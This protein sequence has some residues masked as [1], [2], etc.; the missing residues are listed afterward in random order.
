MARLV[1]VAAI[2]ILWLGAFAQKPKASGSAKQA[3]EKFMAGNYEGALEE[4]RVLYSS[5]QKN[6]KYNY[7]I[8]ICYLNTNIDKK[9]AIPYLEYVTS[10]D[11]Y[12][13]NALYLLGRAYHFANRFD[14][15]IKAYS[16]FKQKGEGTP[17]NLQ[18]ADK[19]IEFCYNA[20][21][22]IKFPLNVSFENLGKNVNSPYID[23][24]PFVPNDE[25]FLVYNSRRDEGAIIGVD[26]RF[27]ADVFMSVEKGGKWQKSKP[28]G[29]E[30]N[31]IEGDEE[32]AGLSADGNNAIFHFDNNIGFGDLLLSLKTGTTFSKPLHLGPNINSKGIEIAAAIAPGG[33]TV[34]FASNRPGGYGGMDLYK[35]THLPNGEWSEAF[36]LG[37]IINTSSDEDFPTISHDGKTLYFSSKGHTTMGGYDIFKAT[38]DSVNDKWI[39]VKNIGYPINTSDDNMNL[40]MSASG[41]HGYISAVRDEGLGDHDIYRV[42]FNDVE[43]KYTVV[44]G[45]IGSNDGY[46]SVSNVNITVTAQNGDVF[47]TYLPNPNTGRYVM[48]LPPGRYD[49]EYQADGFKTSVEKME[50]LDKSSFQ[51]EISKDIKLLSN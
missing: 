28:L 18:D 25:S 7:R 37:P 39:A 33:T 48:I 46:K 15:A 17:A 42:V 44:K 1:I 34:Y 10:L 22:L 23:Y 38:H 16:K 11:K 2:S 24:F 36:N 5:D 29:P 50:I 43:P 14:D 8:A 35:S 45:I 32:M 49:V 30:I 27:T 31:T 26:G 40:C 47:G 3:N 51:T 20:K 21:E 13:N 9:K 19:Q 12:D 6:E 4:Y 41:R